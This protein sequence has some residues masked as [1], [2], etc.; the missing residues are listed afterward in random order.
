[1]AW[2]DQLRQTQKKIDGLLDRIVE[3]TT[4]SVIAAYEK[5]IADLEKEAA[6]LAEKCENRLCRDT[7]SSKCSNSPPFSSQAL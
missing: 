1:M 5:R 4:P 7:P 6:I 2:K 3:S